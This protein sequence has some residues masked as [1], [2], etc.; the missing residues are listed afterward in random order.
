MNVCACIFPPVSKQN[1]YVA[2]RKLNQAPEN[3]SFMF[4]TN[5]RKKGMYEKQEV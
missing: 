5:W 3:N 2:F 1:L 4:S